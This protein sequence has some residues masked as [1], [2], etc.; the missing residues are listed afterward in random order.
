MALA[1]AAFEILMGVL[2]LAL[3]TDHFMAG[4]YFGVAGV[5][6][7]MWSTTFSTLRDGLLIKRIFLIPVSILP[8]REI[9]IVRPHKKNEKWSY[10][11]V[12]EILSRA[13]TKLVFQPDHPQQFLTLL[14]EQAPQANFQL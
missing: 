11:T 5:L 7:F 4:I 12:V 14:R 6:L 1:I 9:E 8:V 13:G 3:K 10:G 2:A